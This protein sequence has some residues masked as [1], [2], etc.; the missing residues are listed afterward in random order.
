MH[1][2]S[3]IRDYGNEGVDVF[4]DIYLIS[5]LK[6]KAVEVSYWGTFIIIFFWRFNN[7]SISTTK[8]YSI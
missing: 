2:C 4:M 3:T 8:M 5:V 1:L 7:I 6:P